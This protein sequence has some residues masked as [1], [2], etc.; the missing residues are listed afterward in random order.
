MSVKIRS[1]H[2]LLDYDAEDKRFSMEASSMGY[3]A[4]M[5]YPSSVKVESAK[6]G[7][8]VEFV[9]CD[10]PNGFIDKFAFYLPTEECGVDDLIIFND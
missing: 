2:P 5:G 8:V 10:K 9:P 7:R 3:S 1:D 4:G 6:T